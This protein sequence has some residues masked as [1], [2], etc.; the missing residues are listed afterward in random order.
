MPPRREVLE[1]LLS[2][3]S[4]GRSLQWHSGPNFRVHA[5]FE[6]AASTDS[7]TFERD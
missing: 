1:P 2:P 5:G 7:I 3:G 6:P 4:G